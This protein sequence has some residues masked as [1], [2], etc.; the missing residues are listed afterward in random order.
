[1]EEQD[2]WRRKIVELVNNLDLKTLQ[3]VYFF[4]VGL[5]RRSVRTVKNKK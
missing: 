5:E 2:A 1:M 3:L 4:I